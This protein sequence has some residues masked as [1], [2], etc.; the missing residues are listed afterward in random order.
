MKEK[1]SA[2]FK[3]RLIHLFASAI[4]LG[5]IIVVFVTYISSGEIIAAMTIMA[6][7]PLIIFITLNKTR[8]RIVR[9]QPILYLILYIILSDLYKS[10]SDATIIFAFMPFTAWLIVPKKT[11]KHNIFVVLGSIYLLMLLLFG[12]RIRIEIKIFITISI[13]LFYYLFVFVQ[14][15]N[16]SVKKI[17]EQSKKAT[18]YINQKFKKSHKKTP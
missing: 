13:Y 16:V 18:T 5:L 15:S 12:A 6:T 10:L 17:K 8:V 2:F 14:F 9:F 4:M 11:I 3:E 7:S 1:M